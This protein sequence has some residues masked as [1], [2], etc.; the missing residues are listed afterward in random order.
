MVRTV[1]KKAFCLGICQN[2]VNY[3]GAT[4]V[5]DQVPHRSTYRQNNSWAVQE[6]PAEWLHVHCETNRPARDISWDCRQCARN[7]YQEPSEVNTQ[8]EPGNADAS[9]KYLA[10]SAQMSSVKG[11]WLQ[12][13]QALSP[14]DHNLHFRFWVELLVSLTNCLLHRWFFVV[15]GPKPPWHHHNWPSFSKF[16]DTERF[17]IPSLSCFVT[18]AP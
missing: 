12:T 3:D 4:E 13:L 18:T 6:I 14:Q 1:D 5:S 11:Y 17:L 8:R 16:Q 9:V 7:F 2:W 10:H 15:L